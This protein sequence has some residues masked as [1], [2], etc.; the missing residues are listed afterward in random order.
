MSRVSTRDCPGQNGLQPG[1]NPIQA[2]RLNPIQAFLIRLAR[3]QRIHSGN[4]WQPNANRCLHA[5]LLAVL[6]GQKLGAKNPG[7]RCDAGRNARHGALVRRL[8]QVMER[9]VEIHNVH[10]SVCL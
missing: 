2:F 9:L 1:L 6:R 10:I 8:D 4:G 5:K 3:I 7:T